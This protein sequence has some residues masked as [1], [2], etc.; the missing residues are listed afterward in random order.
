MSVL[1]GRWNFDGRPADRKYLGRAE[2]M[3]APYGP[4]GGGIYIKDSVG[5]LF[6]ALH[7]TSESRIEAQPHIAPSA[8][9]LTWD[10]RLDNRD[11]L[12]RELSNIADTR[13]TDVSIVAAAYERWGAACFFEAP[14]GLGAFH[15]ESEGPVADSG[16]RCHRHAT[17]VLFGRKRA[18]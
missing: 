18:S 10:G 7:T 6:R 14:R 12:V 3:L 1:F 17:S 8:A 16:Q 13:S 11:G 15:L 2:G 9:V 5:I 4:D